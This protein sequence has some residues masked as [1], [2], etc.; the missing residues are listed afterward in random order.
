M[1]TMMKTVLL[2][3]M[4][5][6]STQIAPAQRK[7]LE[8]ENT[9]KQTTKQIMSKIK[10]ENL[11]KQIYPYGLPKKI[12]T[13]GS[14]GYLSTTTFK[15]EERDLIISY[16]ASVKDPLTN[17]IVKIKDEYSYIDCASFAPSGFI[18]VGNHCHDD[19]NPDL[20]S[21]IYY[22][23]YEIKEKLDSIPPSKL[24]NIYDKVLKEY[25]D[26]KTPISHRGFIMLDEVC[27]HSVAGLLEE[28]PDL[29]YRTL[30]IVS[31]TVG[32]FDFYAA[33]WIYK[34]TL[35]ERGVPVKCEILIEGYEP[36]IDGNQKDI[37]ESYTKTYIY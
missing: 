25:N 8:F 1:K 24:K 5:S 4:M 11:I 34:W 18:Q 12:I 33:I 27:E 10:L 2:L 30:P 15:M 28:N 26:V 29:F 35:D 16:E 22:S 31:E 9:P 7:L 17:E 37:K 32:D 23:L 21:K 19:D 14:D 20:D 36:D 3:I 6:M 13:K